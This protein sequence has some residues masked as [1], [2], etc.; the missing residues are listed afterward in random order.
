MSRFRQL[1]QRTT[2]VAHR[3]K[4]PAYSIEQFPSKASKVRTSVSPSVRPLELANL[5][6]F[7]K[8]RI[9]KT[10]HLSIVY[11]RSWTLPSFD[12]GTCSSGDTTRSTFR[13]EKKLHLLVVYFTASRDRSVLLFLSNSPRPIQRL[14]CTIHR[15]IQP[16]DGI[17]VKGVGW[18]G[19]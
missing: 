7:R 4:P 14:R 10:L 5:R 13:L 15:E 16:T 9:Y 1:P 12:R 2:L 6:P 18:G 19:P 8:F 17:R 11:N 3:E